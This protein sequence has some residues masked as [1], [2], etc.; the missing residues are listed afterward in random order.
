M[1]QPCVYLVCA[2]HCA[3]V[4][5]KPHLLIAAPDIPRGLH[6]IDVGRPGE[7]SIATWLRS[8][9][10]WAARGYEAEALV[11]ARISDVWPFPTLA[12]AEAWRRLGPH[13]LS[14]VRLC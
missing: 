9:Q 13:R 5:S 6:D 4:T 3:Y 1:A 7:R 8:A 12:A 11:L 10:D 14:A 2:A